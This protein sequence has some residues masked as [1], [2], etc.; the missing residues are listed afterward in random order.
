MK[1][2]I[3]SKHYAKSKKYGLG[4]TIEEGNN[5]KKH[6]DVSDFISDRVSTSKNAL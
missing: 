3:K 6:K 4:D 2:H 1:Q 5:E